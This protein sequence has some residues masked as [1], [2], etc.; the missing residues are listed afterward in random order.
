[1]KRKKDLALAKS[2][3]SLS[4]KSSQD[5]FDK[6]H[7]PSILIISKCCFAPKVIDISRLLDGGLLYLRCG[8]APPQAS[9]ATLSSVPCCIVFDRLK[10]SI[11]PV[12]NSGFFGMNRHFSLFYKISAPFFVIFTKRRGR[13][14]NVKPPCS[15]RYLSMAVFGFCRGNAVYFLRGVVRARRHL[16]HVLCLSMFTKRCLPQ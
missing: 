6:L 1:M 14:K 11:F 3:S 2:F 4:K 5:F 16:G 8:L 13:P 10:Y 12:R 9:P 7:P 15:E